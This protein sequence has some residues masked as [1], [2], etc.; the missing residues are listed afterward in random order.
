VPWRANGATSG[1]EFANSGQRGASKRAA[2][3]R[4]PFVIHYSRATIAAAGDLNSPTIA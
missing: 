2:A 4:R 1:V 3:A